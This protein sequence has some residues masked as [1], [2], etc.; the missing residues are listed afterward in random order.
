MISTGIQYLDKMTGG[1]RLGDNVVW[2][3]ADGISIDIFIKSFFE[4][5]RN[6]QKN[7]IYVNSNYSPHTICKRYNY[8]FENDGILIDAFTHGKGKSDPVFLDF[9]SDDPQPPFEVV[10]I[11]NPRDVSSFM[12][13]LNE[14]EKRHREGSFYIFDS[15]TGL[16]ELWKDERAVIDFF[17]F[18]CP[19]LYDLNTLAF[20]VFE[21][22][23]HTKEFVASITHITQIV[24]S[25]S[26]SHAD[27]YNFVINKMENRA[28]MGEGDPGYFRIT[29][30]SVIFAM[31]KTADMIRIGE[32]VKQVRKEKRITQADLALVLGLTAGAVSQIENNITTPSLQTLVQMAKYF[33]KPV[34]YFTDVESEGEKNQGFQI[35]RRGQS[36]GDMS[37]PVVIR[38]LVDNPSFPIMPSVIKIEPCQNLQGPILLHKGIEY[39]YVNEGALDIYINMELIRLNRGDSVILE[40]TFVSQWK[41]DDAGCELF[42]IL[43]R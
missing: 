4:K 13:T 17:V 11:E 38:E 26:L 32:K 25:L 28:S 41:T 19:K 43:L 20:W 34:G 12:S 36:E 8:I 27:L 5:N 3:V 37:R 7:I 18:T 42:Y 23:A 40:S 16:F 2:Q 33:N 9:Y 39:F 15:L 24:F 22:D 1:F 35:L 14:I 6:F 30:E 10:C 31:E 29:E 21:R